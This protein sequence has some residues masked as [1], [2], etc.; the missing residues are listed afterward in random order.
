MKSKK[1]LKKGKA[2]SNTVT[3]PKGYKLETIQL[4]MNEIDFSQDEETLD[5]LLQ[6][7][8]EKVYNKNCKNM[9]VIKVLLKP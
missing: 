5:H 6:R 1:A 2:K 9:T 7:D 3:S 8:L 4:V